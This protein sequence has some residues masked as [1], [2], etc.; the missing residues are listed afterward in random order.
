MTRSLYYTIFLYRI[1]CH[2]YGYGGS[3]VMLY[4]HRFDLVDY[5]YSILSDIHLV[6]TAVYG[7]LVALRGSE[8]QNQ[9]LFKT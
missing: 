3:W 2:A 7:M 5:Y 9:T 1:S 4:E 6:V 8:M